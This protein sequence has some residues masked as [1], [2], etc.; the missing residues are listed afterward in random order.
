MKRRI[1]LSIFLLTIISLFAVSATLCAVFYLQLSDS[2]QSEVRERAAMLKD[3][4]APEKFDAI[5]ITD[6]RLTIVSA[7]GV[8]LYD[9]EQDAG[10]LLNHSD[11][12]E[13]KE[14]V[15]SGVGESRRFSDTLGQE[16][17]YYA[18]K[19]SDGSILRLAKTMN[20]IFGLFRGSI[21]MVTN[22]VMFA[23]F[24]GYFF[25]GNLTK[26]IVGPINKVDLSKEVVSPYDELVPFVRTITQQKDHIDKQVEELK[27]RTTTI[28]VI[29][30]SMSEGIIIIDPKGI[31][32]SVN[33]SAAS[34]FDIRAVVGKN[35]LE[36]FRNIE[37]MENVRSALDGIRSEMNVEQGESVYRAYFSPVQNSGAIILFL[38]I[39]ERVN[40]ER[41]RR[42]FSA[43]VSHELKTPLTSIYGHAEMLSS[44]MVK[45]GDEQ[46]FYKKIKDET[47]RM[48]TLIDDIIL[49]SRLDETGEADYEQFELIELEDIATEALAT[50]QQKANDKGILVNLTGENIQMKANRSQIYELFLNLID[51][52]IKYSNPEGK[53]NIG[54]NRLQSGRIEILVSDTGIGIPED[55]QDRVFERFYRV[56]KSRSKSTGGTGL[57]LAIVKHIVLAHRGKIHLESV[58]NKGTTIRIV[59]DNE[60]EQLSSTFS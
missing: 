10:T 31:V 37:L 33:K 57:G 11:R 14:A 22:V 15:E 2:V 54:L 12:E 29:M 34:F 46:A 4:V 56:D 41:L 40:A 7:D 58:E 28:E 13:I 17:Y 18:I 3:T 48:I 44:G 38:D 55:V 6:M 1:F 19:L 32:L 52:S 9:N 35:I 8:V 27:N 21:P 30:N 36:L 42:E 45:V 50:L 26:R 23:V 43:N 24:A 59:L 39:T 49:I 47:A 53:I 25:A 51:N 5:T 60:L 16:T 20:S